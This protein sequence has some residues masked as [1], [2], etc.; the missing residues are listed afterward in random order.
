M[1]TIA[2]AVI[3]AC[4]IWFGVGY[5]KNKPIVTEPLSDKPET[6]ETLSSSDTVKVVEPPIDFEKYKALNDEIY[7]W[8]SIPNA[9]VNY[10][11][12]QSEAER[13]YYLTHNIDK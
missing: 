9:N 13:S 4:L 10:P 12:L 5:F 3:T 8:I 1:L 6:S 2:V 7:A 11:I